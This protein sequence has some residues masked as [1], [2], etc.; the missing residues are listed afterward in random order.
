MYDFINYISHPQSHSIPNFSKSSRFT[1][2]DDNRELRAMLFSVIHIPPLP[3]IVSRVDREDN[4]IVDES[5]VESSHSIIGSML[6]WTA[7]AN[8]NAANTSRM[9]MQCALVTQ[10]KSD[11]LKLDPATCPVED[12]YNFYCHHTRLWLNTYSRVGNMMR[13][14]PLDYVLNNDKTH[15]NMRGYTKAQYHL[16]TDG[17][18]RLDLADSVSYADLLRKC[19]QWTKEAYEAEA[20]TDAKLASTDAELASTDA[21]LASTD[22]ELASTEAKLA[23]TEAKLAGSSDSNT[24]DTH[25]TCNNL[26]AGRVEDVSE[27]NGNIDTID[28]NGS[29]PPKG[30]EL[31]QVE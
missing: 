21:E 18:E 19:A 15:Q 22:A 25:N 31:I 6:E 27:D 28:F 3:S 14:K 8:N 11:L 17:K 1:E 29:S 2:M 9:N 24:G 16:F 23:S 4:S 20:S 7:M 5:A 10:F 26:Q 13:F 30:L 12:L